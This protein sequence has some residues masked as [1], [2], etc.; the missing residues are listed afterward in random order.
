M[1]LILASTSPRRRELIQLFGLEFHFVSVEVDE[2]P[3][4]GESAPELV[5]RL[6]REKAAQAATQARDAVVIAADTVVALDR[7]I[8]GK[9]RDLRDAARMLHQLRGRDHFVYTGFCAIQDARQWTQVVKTTV[10]MR[11]YTDA[12]IAAYVATGN[13]LDKAAAYAIQHNGFRPV[14]YIEGC[15]ANVMGLPV[16]HLYL[17]VKSFDVAVDTP[18]RVC[19]EYLKIECPVAGMILGEGIRGDK[20]S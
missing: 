9:P 16:C 4:V 11:P 8:L 3:R 17:A 7:E 19:Q 20:K 10:Q 5:E 18:D 13:P 2:T 12:Q 6:S 1:E 14:A 15:Y